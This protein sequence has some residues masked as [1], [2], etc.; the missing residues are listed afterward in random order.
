MQLHTA[1]WIHLLA[2]SWFVMLAWSR[3]GLDSVRR[4]NITAIGAAAVAITVFASLVLPHL[5]PLAVARATREWMALLL[6]PMLYWQ[7][8]Q[9]VTRAD[10]HFEEWLEQLDSGLVAPLLEWCVRSPF[11]DWIFTYL[12]VAYLSYYVTLPLALVAL[13]LVGKRSEIGLFWTVVLLGAYGSCNT[14]P[15]LQTRPPRVLGEKWSAALPSGKMRAF[16]QWILLQGSIH[17]NTFPSV[18]VAIATDCALVLLRVGPLWM[19]LGFLW[20]AISI[21]LGAVGGRYHYAADAI[22]GAAAAVAAFLTGLAL[23]TVRIGG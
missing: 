16:N 11:R 17:A 9:F 14:L 2:F 10:I 18:H 6:L 8:G 5:A 3:R 20:I 4:T 23:A 13:Y 19:G 22:F 7:A 1:E 21:A 12:E 15:F